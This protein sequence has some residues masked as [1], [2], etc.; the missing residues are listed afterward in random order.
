[1]AATSTLVLTREY[2]PHKIIS[3]ERAVMMI[4]QGKITVVEE[5][6]EEFG[7]IEVHRKRDFPN[8]VR[9]Y[10]NRFNLD[11]PIILKAPSV[12][13]L[14]SAVVHM[15]RGVKFSRMNVFARDGFRCQYCLEHKLSKALNFDHLI[16]RQQG[17]KTDWTNIV[18]SCYPCNSKKANRTP[19]Q[20]GMKLRRLPFKPRTLPVVGPRFSPQDISESWLQYLGDSWSSEEIIHI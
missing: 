11:E 8:V 19:D 6:S 13:A 1:M 16:P 12:V 20:A 2:T 15:K 4:F 9:S 18:T 17:G 7:K 3:Q 5:Y 10:G 14:R